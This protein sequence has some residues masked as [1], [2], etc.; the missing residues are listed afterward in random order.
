MRSA[1]LEELDVEG[2][3]D[4]GDADVHCHSWPELMPEE[5][6]VHAYRGGQ[7][8]DEH[9]E[10]DERASVHDWNIATAAHGHEAPARPAEAGT[11]SGPFAP[12]DIG[13]LYV[14]SVKDSAEARPATSND[15]QATKKLLILLVML[16][17]V[18]VGTAIIV[19]ASVPAYGN[20]ARSSYTQAHGVRRVAEVM[21]QNAGT[22][23]YPSRGGGRVPTS[24]AAVWLSEPVNGHD[25]TTVHV[26][27]AP[28]YPDASVTVLVDPQDPGYAELPGA[29]FT[30][31]ASWLGPL[32]LGL[33]ILVIPFG[34]GV[35]YLR[36]LR[37]R[38]RV[39]VPA[40]LT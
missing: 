22:E 31:I 8:R 7:H 30:T 1:L 16:G 6:E 19:A 21:I 32:G 28:L 18:A 11:P 15:G 36:A 37:G 39:S 2:S 26:H 24:T 29:P 13:T 23:D 25:T 4:R 12:Y 33:T 14:G 20:A 34:V 35:G 3:E 27:G 10:H 38:R 9:V 5:E 17:M 40:A